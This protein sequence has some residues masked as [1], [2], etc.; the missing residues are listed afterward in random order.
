LPSQE[1]GRR[2][3]AFPGPRVLEVTGKKSGESR[4]R[5]SPFV[6]GFDKA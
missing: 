6:E 3:S 4:M 5:L 1:M 2:C